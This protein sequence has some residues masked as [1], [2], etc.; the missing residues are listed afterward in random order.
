MWSVECTRPSSVRQCTVPM[1]CEHK[2]HSLTIAW[3]HVDFMPFQFPPWHIGSSVKW[4]GTLSNHN[5][6]LFKSALSEAAT[7]SWTTQP[8]TAATKPCIA[9]SAARYM[10]TWINTNSLFKTV[11][12]KCWKAGQLRMQLPQM[13]SLALDS[14]DAKFEWALNCKKLFK[15]PLH[16]LPLQRPSKRR[17]SIAARTWGRMIILFIPCLSNLTLIDRSK[18]STGVGYLGESFSTLCK[19]M[20]RL[21]NV[22]IAFII[23]PTRFHHT[24]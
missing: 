21:S 18:F 7:W 10:F 15:N 16:A 20:K 3:P 23:A 19:W 4:H 1:K 12:Q 5:N 24:S 8:K 6:L 13:C 9:A 14:T 2:A 22:T 17:P 11:A